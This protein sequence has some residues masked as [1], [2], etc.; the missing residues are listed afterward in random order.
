[1]A[2]VV[3]GVTLRGI[4]GVFAVLGA[5]SKAVMTTISAVTTG[6]RGAAKYLLPFHAQ[7]SF[8]T[9]IALCRGPNLFYNTTTTT[10]YCSFTF[11]QYDVVYNVVYHIAILFTIL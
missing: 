6:I 9:V 10:V 8:A 3:L 1:M 2:C 7:V 4:G 5:T 11:F